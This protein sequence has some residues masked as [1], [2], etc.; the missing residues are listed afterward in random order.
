MPTRSDIFTFK[1]CLGAETT[2]NGD[3]I[4]MLV[5]TPVMVRGASIAG[6]LE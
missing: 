4:H 3:V 1:L 2:S 6:L 5:S